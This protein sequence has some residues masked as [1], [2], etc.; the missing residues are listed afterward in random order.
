MLHSLKA[1]KPAFGTSNKII[2]TPVEE[3]EYLNNPTN[4][5]EGWKPT[6]Y[7]TYFA[8]PMQVNYA[9]ESFQIPHFLHKDTP[10]LQILAD[11]MSS[12]V[13]LREIREQGGAYGGGCNITPNGVLNFYS[14]RDPHTLQTYKA[15]E[16]AIQWAVEGK[17]S[18]Q[19]M[20]E[21]KLKVFSNVDQVESPLDKGLRFFIKGISDNMRKEY[22]EGL[23][24]VTKDDV[25]EVA[26]KYLYGSIKDGKT[27]QVIFGTQDNDLEKFLSRGWKIERPVEGL[28]VSEEK[29]E[30]NTKSNPKLA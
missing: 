5:S 6:F 1:N 13:L 22:R 15:F 8:L 24:S 9:V 26:Q 23:L 28:S 3:M 14:Y 27:S 11:L 16:R 20:K 2:L 25:I 29:Y 4:D 17:M 12:N 30:Q 10:K 18:E 19:D 7:K 21:A